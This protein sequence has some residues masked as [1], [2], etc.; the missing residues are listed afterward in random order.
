MRVNCLSYLGWIILLLIFFQTSS[1]FSG[2]VY[3]W[4]DEKGTIHFTDDGST[5]PKQY[6]DRAEKIEVPEEIFKE[7]EKPDQPEERSDRI[8]K[9]LKDFEKRIGEKK[10]I[11]KR[12]SELEEEMKSSEEDLKRIE[13]FEKEDYLYYQPFKDPQTGKWIAVASPYHEEKRRLKNRIEL[14]KVELRSLQGKLSEINRS[15]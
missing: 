12:I 8:K 15:L 14:I 2:E 3:R 1:S 7:A 5:I 13:E 11:E 6:S 10:K 4:T 9:Y